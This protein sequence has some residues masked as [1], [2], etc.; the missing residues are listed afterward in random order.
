MKKCFIALRLVQGKIRFSHLLHKEVKS[1]IRK[2][3][4]GTTLYLVEHLQQ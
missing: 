1:V 3:T 4:V 2:F